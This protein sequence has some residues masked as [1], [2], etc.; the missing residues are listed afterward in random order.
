MGRHVFDTA[1]RGW[2][3]TAPGFTPLF[4]CSRLSRRLLLPHCN[5][6]LITAV[7]FSEYSAKQMTNFLSIWFV[8]IYAWTLF[9]NSL[10]Y[11][12]NKSKR[13]ILVYI[14]H[15]AF[16]Q[17]SH[18]II[19]LICNRTWI[20]LYST[21]LFEEN[22]TKKNKLLSMKITFNDLI[23]HHFSSFKISGSVMYVLVQ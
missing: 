4:R 16:F 12:N 8:I 14:L 23:S 13:Q 7:V 10:N 2:R 15:D 21:K 18:P 11:Q 5:I 19:I 9:N 3:Q 20:S 17:Q 6:S 1:T 22:S